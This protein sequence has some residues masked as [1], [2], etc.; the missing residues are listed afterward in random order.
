[1]IAKLVIL[2]LSILTLTGCGNNGSGSVYVPEDKVTLNINGYVRIQNINF[3]PEICGSNDRRFKDLSVFGIKIQDEKNETDVSMNGQFNLN[4]L[5][6][7]QQIVIQCYDKNFPNLCFEW[8]RASSNGLSGDIK[9]DITLE[10]TAQSFIARALRDRYGRRV[11][12]EAIK[13]KYLE[14]TVNAIA[15]VIEQQPGKLENARLDQIDTVLAAYTEMADKL[16]A[17]N[18]GDF[19]LQ[20]VFLFY[21][22]GDNDL[23]Q[24]MENT[25]RSIAEAGQPDKT[26]III[27]LDS[28]HSLPILNKPGAARYRVV[29]NELRLLNELGDLDSTDS[30]YLQNFVELSMR[31]YPAKEYSLILSSH[32]GVWRDR[33]KP[34]GSARAIFMNDTTSVA[35][36]TVLNIASAIKCALIDNNATNRKID[37]LVLDSCNMG[38]IET[39]YEFAEIADYTIFSQALM[40][41][42]GIPYASFF[43]DISDK[44]VDKTNVLEKAKLLADLYSNKYVTVSGAIDTGISIIDNSKMYG[45]MA[46]YNNFL[47][48]IWEN[49][50]EYLPVI[51][52][53]RTQRTTNDGENDSGSV[54]RCFSSTN[55]FVD[56]PQLCD[57]C[58]HDKQLYF[59][60]EKYDQLKGHFD[61]LI[62]Y[63]KYSN[64]LKNA[65]GLSITFPEKDTYKYYYRGELKEGSPLQPEATEYFNLKFCHDTKWV[66]ILN[67]MMK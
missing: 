44:G 50:N 31:E 24:S 30:K 63:S 9:A 12:P 22:A 13:G 16:A 8:M 5:Q 51:Y 23:A 53:I 38:C 39:A 25:I 64:I 33:S 26:E 61:L 11:N 4:E 41:A 52:N 49:K 20:H 46:A 3:P 19:P 15:E 36:G 48:V 35:T 60:N 37:L 47:D 21:M 43:R 62:V 59:L 10:T 42:S 27:G 65:N 2:L 28:V 18:S 54:I 66:E 29:G 17:G 56:L 14:T 32:G 57:M 34:I 67:E 58:I 7:R 6:P 40:P 45:F 55:E 1:M